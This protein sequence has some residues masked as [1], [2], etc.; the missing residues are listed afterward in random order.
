M[1][2]IRWLIPVIL[3]GYIFYQSFWANS[4]L[5]AFTDFS[6]RTAYFDVLLPAGRVERSATGIIIQQEP[7]YIDLRVPIRTGRVS[8]ELLVTAD[9]A[10]IKLGLQTGPEFSFDF[11]EQEIV[12]SADGLAYY[13]YEAREIKYVRPGNK[14][15]FIISSP[16][17]QAGDVVIKGAKV[18]LNRK[19]ADIDWWFR[20][21]KQL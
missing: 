14:I 13:N 11:Q 17:L 7:V 9:S 4:L 1:R 6:Q 20:I 12:K 5:V 19:K 3:L 18:S 10:P 2:H 15:R 16:G 8:L 21:I